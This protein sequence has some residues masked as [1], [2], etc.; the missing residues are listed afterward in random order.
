MNTFLP[1]IYNL[2]SKKVWVVRQVVDR[3][4]KGGNTVNL[5]SVDL[6]K[7]F[8]KV[9]HHTLLIK[10][11]DLLE[12]WLKICFSRIKWGNTFWHIFA[13]KFGVRQGS[14][15]SPLLF[16]IYL[17]DIPIARSLVARSSIVLYTD[18][19]LLI[20]P[21]VHELQRLFKNCQ[22]ELQWLDMRIKK[23]SCCL[24]IGPRF[25]VTFAQITTSDGYSLPWVDQIRYLGIY[26]TTG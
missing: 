20:A 19:I 1:I 2:D 22:R 25:K 13:I 24:R 12:N 16:A 15:L 10:L 9:N 4:I 3:F 7:A 5:C 21:S 8:D 6:S 23:K 18:D 17:D 11:L 26:L 14:V